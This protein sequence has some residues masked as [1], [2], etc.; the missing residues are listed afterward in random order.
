MENK[1]MPALE[2]TFWDLSVDFEDALRQLVD[3]GHDV[4]LVDFILQEVEP[5]AEP[6]G[7]TVT[8]EP[9]FTLAWKK[10]GERGIPPPLALALASVLPVKAATPNTADPQEDWTNI[11][12]YIFLR[13]K[14]R[15]SGEI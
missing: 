13:T 10:K 4:N 6:E 8:P 2:Y 5:P 9:K 15:Y 11:R 1:N 3:A 14:A 12:E 7:S